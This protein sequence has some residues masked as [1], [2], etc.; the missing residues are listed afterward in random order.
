MARPPEGLTEVRAVRLHH[1]ALKRIDAIARE[2]GSS[3][4][5][6]IRAIIWQG[7][8]SW[9]APRKL[10]NPIQGDE[11]WRGVLGQEGGR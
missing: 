5:A 6:T 8:N 11:H 3:R 9:D 2:Q 7:L 1:E 10:K 4:A